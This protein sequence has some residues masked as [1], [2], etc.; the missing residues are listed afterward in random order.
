M[1]LVQNLKKTLNNWVDKIL[2]AASCHY[3]RHLAK[4]TTKKQDNSSQTTSSQ[5]RLTSE[6]PSTTI[7]TSSADTSEKI[8]MMETEDL[9]VKINEWAMD[10]FLEPLPTKDCL[11]IYQEFQEWLEPHGED[12]EVITL[13]EI[14]EEEYEDF[15]ERG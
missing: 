14:S 6:S 11:A 7:V 1:G 2:V 12:L 15:I 9:V 4:Q 5:S 3:I 13:D 8:T 10:R